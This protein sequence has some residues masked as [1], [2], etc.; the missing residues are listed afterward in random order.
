[1]LYVVLFMLIFF[2]SLYVLLLKLIART[3]FERLERKIV[4][5]RRYIASQDDEVPYHLEREVLNW[6][7]AIKTAHHNL[8]KPYGWV[9]T[10]RKWSSIE[11]FYPEAD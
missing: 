5:V 7:H 8:T 4:E 10:S 9:F 11:R 6:D 1:M 3:K 2:G